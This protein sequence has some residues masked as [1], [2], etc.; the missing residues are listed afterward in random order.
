MSQVAGVKSLQLLIFVLGWTEWI[1]Y[2]FLHLMECYLQK[3][4]HLLT[5]RFDISF[6]KIMQCRNTATCCC[7]PSS[8]HTALLP[9]NGRFT[10]PWMNGIG[11][12]NNNK[13]FI[14]CNICHKILENHPQH[15]E[16]KSTTA[17]DTW[18]LKIKQDISLTRN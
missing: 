12:T 6:K 13:H 14:S 15:S 8:E 5:E 2:L 17:V 16:T 18:H 7:A 10:N 3:C 9:K 4:Q 1:Q 11:I